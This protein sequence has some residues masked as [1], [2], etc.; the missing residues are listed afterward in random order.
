MTV[1]FFCD[2]NV[3]RLA[4]W[5]RFAGFD[6]MSRKELSKEK[7]DY[8]CYKDRRIFISR[9]QKKDIKQFKSK[10]E[11]LISDDVFKQLDYC[12][13]KYR[14]NKNLIATRCIECNVVM[15]ECNA[16]VSIK[17]CSRCGK[18]FWKGTHFQEMYNVIMNYIE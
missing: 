16:D 5:L 10:I 14:V 2:T 18:K 1:K 13:S 7:I 4:K 8:I 6:T 12:L 17:F 3:L 11:I 15:T 9:S